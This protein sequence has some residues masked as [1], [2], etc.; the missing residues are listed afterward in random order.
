MKA[1]EVG[2]SDFHWAPPRVAARAAGA[3]HG[4]TET[5][6]HESSSTSPFRQ[7][8][9]ALGDHCPNSLWSPH[10][11]WFS[12]SLA[13][14]PSWAAPRSPSSRCHL[15]RVSSWPWIIRHPDEYAPNTPRV[16]SVFARHRETH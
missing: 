4:L 12:L 10:R 15:H 2:T 9:L 16:F 7:D 1:V 8:E 3:E 5:N 11:H 14:E 6:P 13:A